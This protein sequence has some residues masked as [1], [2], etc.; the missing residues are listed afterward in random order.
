MS[1]PVLRAAHALLVDGP[2][3]LFGVG[4][5]GL[6]VDDDGFDDLVD[7]RLAGHLVQQIRSGHQRRPKADGQVPGVH[8]V[9]IAVLRETAGQKDNKRMDLTT[10]NLKQKNPQNKKKRQGARTESVIKWSSLPFNKTF[11]V[12]DI[13]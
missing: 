4:E 5:D 13:T 9:L 1:S 12:C 2:L 11:R 7:M 8:H 3:Q 10:E 6:V